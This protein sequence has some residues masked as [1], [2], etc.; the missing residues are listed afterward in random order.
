MSKLNEMNKRQ[1][2]MEAS[3]ALL[4]E[5]VKKIAPHHN[6]GAAVPPPPPKTPPRLLPPVVPSS[7]TQSLETPPNFHPLWSLTTAVLNLLCT[8]AFLGTE[9]QLWW[10]HDSSVV[11]SMMDVTL[12]SPS[13][14]RFKPTKH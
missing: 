5:T 14:S 10:H 9:K 7:S 8:P 1:E 3:L 12:L 4:H 2:Q 6:L 13:T 11:D